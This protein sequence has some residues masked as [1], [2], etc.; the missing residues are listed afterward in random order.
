MHGLSLYE[1]DD[2]SAHLCT[3]DSDSSGYWGDPR[4]LPSE[5][6]ID[7]TL[8]C[9]D[10]LETLAHCS[11]N[12]SAALTQL[13]STEIKIAMIEGSPDCSSTNKVGFIFIFPRISRLQSSLLFLAFITQCASLRTSV[14]PFGTKFQASTHKMSK[15]PFL[16]MSDLTK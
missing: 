4:T 7:V 3:P 13:I 5:D 16:P 1:C 6:L 12:I 14:K 10:T 8:V 2:R 15:I 11:H 9:E